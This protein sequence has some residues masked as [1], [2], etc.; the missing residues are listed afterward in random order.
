MEALSLIEAMIPTRESKYRE[1]VEKRVLLDADGIAR[2]LENMA[3]EIV[4]QEA[5]HL[6]H[7]L[8]VG[9]RTGGVPLA[10][11]LRGLIQVRVG[12]EVALSEMDIALYRDDVFSGLKLPEVGRTTL[13]KSLDRR[14]IILVDDV[15]YTGRTTRAALGELMDFGRPENVRLAVLVDRGHRELPIRPDFVGIT[16]E[17]SRSETVRVMLREQGELDRVVLYE[18]MAPA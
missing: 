17:T 14:A 18:K 11:R 12:R 1:L 16:V 9:I 6:E 5:S 15:L 10:E 3:D 2:A 8:L 13:P 7:L 4:R